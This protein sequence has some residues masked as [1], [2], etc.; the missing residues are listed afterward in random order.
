MLQLADIGNIIWE[1]IYGC[2]L[3]PWLLMVAHPGSFC[4]KDLMWQN[5]CQE[6]QVL[7]FLPEMVLDSL[8]VLFE[9]LE[10]F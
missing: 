4:R 6:I 5:K 7:W 9:P 8:A 2:K 1:V 3:I 10:G